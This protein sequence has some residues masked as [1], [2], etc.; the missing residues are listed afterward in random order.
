MTSTTRRQSSKL[1]GEV[2]KD[3]VVYIMNPGKRNFHVVLKLEDRPGVL[4]NV[5]SVISKSKTNILSGHISVLD[6]HAYWSFFAE[7]EQGGVDAAMLRLLL[8]NS[9]YVEEATVR[10]DRDGLI[11]DNACFPLRWNAG[12]RAVVFR[13]SAFADTL[14]QLR[15]ELGSGGSVLLYD[16][17]YKMGEDGARS[18][19]EKL[20]DGFAREHLSDVLGLWSAVGWGRIAMLSYDASGPSIVLK[21]EESFECGSVRSDAPYSQFLRGHLCSWLSVLFETRLKCEETVCVSAGGR[22]CEFHLC[23]E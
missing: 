6:G 16:Q 17:G 3:I 18:M 2:P 21:V 4:A 10:E 23:P 1:E 13:T 8:Q 9:R 5:S 20:G 14:A 15:K 22:H 12:D 11:V 7:T 19:V